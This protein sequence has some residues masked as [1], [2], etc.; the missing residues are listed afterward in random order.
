MGYL[1]YKT[2][3]HGDRT[4][5]NVISERPDILHEI[6]FTKNVVLVSYTQIVTLIRNLFLLAY[7]L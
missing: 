7:D 1:T 3:R 4:E 5:M 6:L 2:I